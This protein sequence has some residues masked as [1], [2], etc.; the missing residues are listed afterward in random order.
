MNEP[1]NH[2]SLPAASADG[3]AGAFFAWHDAGELRFQRCTE[4]GRWN[5]PPGTTCP[6]CGSE[7]LEWTPVGGTGTIVSWTRTHY[8]F[9]PPFAADGPY[10]ALVVA[11]DEGPQMVSMLRGGD[12]PRCGGRVRV[13][14]EARADGRRVAVFVAAE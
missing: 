7:S 1:A 3:L 5:H 4:C 13:E 2:P 8:A 14:F 10:V 6:S 9:A 12:E 11:V